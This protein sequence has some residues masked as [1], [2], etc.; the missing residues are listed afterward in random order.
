LLTLN[1]EDTPELI[2]LTKTKFILSYTKNLGLL[3]LEV[4]E[5]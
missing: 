3:H 4:F 1:K 5:W 2:D